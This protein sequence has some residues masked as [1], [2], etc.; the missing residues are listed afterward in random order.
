[1]DDGGLS[2]VAERLGELVQ[3]MGDGDALRVLDE[4][5][6]PLAL[7]R[8]ESEPSYWNTAFCDLVGCTR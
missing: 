3:S 8:G 5:P 2:E 7:V 1:M 6:V 4:Y